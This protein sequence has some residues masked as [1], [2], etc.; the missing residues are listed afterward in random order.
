MGCDIHFYVERRENNR[1]VSCDE[2]VQDPDETNQ[3]VPHEKSFYTGR[4]YDLFAILAGVRNGSGFAGVD[5]GDGFRPIVA[6][7]G[8]PDDVTDLVRAV[9][10]NCGV[11]GHSHSHVTVS[12]LL[13]YDW[14]Q[15]TN[16]R[17][18]VGSVEFERWSRWG[19]KRGESPSSWAGGVGGSGVDHITVQEMDR[20]IGE[21]KAQF[22]NR[23]EFED[24]L[25]ARYGST[26]CHAQWAITYARA[27]SVFLVDS[28]TRL[29]RLG[30]PDDVRIVFWFDN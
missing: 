9:S 10:D 1:W 3:T 30:M 15:T 27:A 4:N 12:E 18:W 29:M 22:P 28:L 6:P 8:L 24:R 2:W 5:T 14:T 11:D 20:R 23:A 16:K 19:R 21:L 7:R 13:A 26:Y 25:K 17:G